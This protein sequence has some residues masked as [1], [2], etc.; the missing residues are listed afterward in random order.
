LSAALAQY[1]AIVASRPK[2]ADGQLGRAFALMGL[3]RLYDARHAL[4]EAARLGGD[5]RV[6]AAQRRE[7]SRRASAAH[8]SAPAPPPSQRDQN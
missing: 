5:P 7:L 3:G 2:L 8:I 1:E 6:V 4:D